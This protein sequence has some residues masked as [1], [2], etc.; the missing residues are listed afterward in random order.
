[1]LSQFED[2]NLR[3][4]DEASLD[5]ALIE[6]YE[7]DSEDVKPVLSGITVDTNFEGFCQAPVGEKIE[8][9][10][11]EIIKYEDVL[12]YQGWLIEYLT[13]TYCIEYVNLIE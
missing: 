2:F 8:E 4:A 1:M 11:D 6:L 7:A 13:S 12:T 9:L 10:V 5:A 3:F